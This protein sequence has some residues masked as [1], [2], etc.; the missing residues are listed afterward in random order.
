MAAKTFHGF[1]HLPTELR[2]SVFELALEL[3]A[4]INVTLHSE[5]IENLKLDFQLKKQ[6]HLTYFPC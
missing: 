5:D 3:P 6:P 4:R 1:N 2:L